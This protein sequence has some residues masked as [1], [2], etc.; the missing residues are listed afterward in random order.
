MQQLDL[1]L[2][3][4]NHNP[5]FTPCTE[6]NGKKSD[7]NVKP[8]PKNFCKKNVREN[9]KDLRLGKE[10]LTRGNAEK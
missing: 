8:K 3:K 4:I 7:V 2:Q 6:I 1:Q 10:F 9:L 5:Y